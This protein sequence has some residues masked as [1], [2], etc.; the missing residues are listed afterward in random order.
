MMKVGVAVIEEVE[1]KEK[2]KPRF[3]TEQRRKF[4]RLIHKRVHHGHSSNVMSALSKAYGDRYIQDNEPCDACMWAKARMKTRSKTHRREARHLGDRL[5]YDLFHG[6]SRSEEGFK[7]VLVVIDEF[8]S[9]SWSKGLKRKS[10]LYE[11]LEQIIR[12]IETKM[13]R[14]RVC[15]L[16]T[17]CSDVPHVVEIRSDN[18]KEEASVPYQQWQNSAHRGMFRKDSRGESFWTESVLIQQCLGCGL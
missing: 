10:G 14:G 13:R 8:T 12:E 1:E 5:H 17:D 3:T 18:A 6:P 16:G 2:R 7:Y 15:S 9:R 4:G 11:A